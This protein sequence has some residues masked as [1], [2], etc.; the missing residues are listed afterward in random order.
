MKTTQEQID[1]LD[2][3]RDEIFELIEEAMDLVS[4]D[5][6]SAAQGYWSAHIKSALGS[7]EYRTYSTTMRDTI[8]EMR[9]ET[10]LGCIDCGAEVEE[11]T[12]V[13][14]ECI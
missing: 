5:E 14:E 9:R 2:E 8:N 11:G 7:D 10:G 3:I 4:D 1:R 12:D 13:C 6:R